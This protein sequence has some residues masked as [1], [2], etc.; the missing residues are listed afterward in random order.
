MNENK[1]LYT[2]LGIVFFGLAGLFIFVF[3]SKSLETNVKKNV[4]D[5]TESIVNISNK[6]LSCDD[7]KSYI[8]QPAYNNQPVPLYGISEKGYAGDSSKISSSNDFSGTNI[9]VEGV[10][11]SDIIKTDGDRLYIVSDEK[12]SL[13]DTTKPENTNLI[14]QIDV[15][16]R[17]LEVF[18]TDKNLIILAVNSHNGGYMPNVR[19][20]YSES[21]EVGIFIYDRSDEI[22]R[23]REV[24]V[25]GDFRNARLT[26]NT[27]YLLSTKN[28]SYFEDDTRAV[29]DLIPTVSDRNSDYVRIGDCNDIYFYGNGKNNLSTITA[30]NLDSGDLKNNV[31]LGSIENVY[32]S[33]NNL[34]LA[35]SVY[36]QIKTGSDSEGVLMEGSVPILPIPR[37]LP[38][39]ENT[40]STHIFKIELNKENINF[41]KVGIVD[42]TLLNQFSMDEYD[43]NFRVAT[44][45]NNTNSWEGFSL[46][47]IFILDQDM[48]IKGELRGLAKNEQIYSV[49]FLGE[50]IYVVT[51]R[52]VDPLFVI[53]A[54]DS[55]KPFVMGEL[56]IPGFSSY[57]HPYD[58]N[59]I[60][61]IGKQIDEL[62]GQTNGLKV[63]LFDIKDPK[64]PIEK[65]NLILGEYHVESEVFNNHKA[66]L[67]DRERELIV[68]P[69]EIYNKDYVVSF[70]GFSVININLGEDSLSERGRISNSVKSKSEVIEDVVEFNPYYYS[71]SQKRSFYINDVLY[72][73]RD[74]QLN[75]FE[76]KTLKRIGTFDL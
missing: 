29:E 1:R 20:S 57:L 6:F 58:E 75:Y 45:E 37:P 52:Q 71:Y 30:L 63:S 26:D 70:V 31:F 41:K 47:N 24:K 27:V 32:M 11:E 4:E 12:V 65:D 10:D 48:N 69:V 28:I 55:T 16:G 8:S 73:L 67:F 60:I 22:V 50:R 5:N 56:K 15:P 35:E 19:Y 36:E 51:F 62:T 3:V 13:F 38:I 68:L 59:H 44:T 7:F 66:F 2:S 74:N 61:G 42:G 72:T 34:Y 39:V 64:N 49:R 18:L 53:D 25:Q 43:G 23:E 76:L 17:P 21:S 33:R 9:Q 40:V 54:S 46:N 14:T